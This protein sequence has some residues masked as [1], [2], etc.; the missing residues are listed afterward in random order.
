MNELNLFLQPK[1]EIA[2]LPVENISLLSATREELSLMASK[3]LESVDDGYAD[4]LDTLIL[5][6]KGLFV[7]EAILESLKG[8]VSIPEEKDFKKHNVS[9]K[10]QLMGVRYS[11][12]QCNDEVWN[13]LNDQKSQIVEAMKARELKLKSLSGSIEV[14]DEVDED[15]GDILQEARTLFPPVKKGTE[16]I[17]LGIK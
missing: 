12:D 9:V 17:V 4:P 14:G 7:F 6:K 11:Y 13:K 15:T 5:A 1:S 10:V 2:V 3:I 8:K 16:T